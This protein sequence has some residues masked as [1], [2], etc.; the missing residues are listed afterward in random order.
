MEYGPFSFFSPPQ[1][2][3]GN[4]ESKQVGI[5]A[6]ELGAKAVLIVTD[7]GII[8]AGLA[9][10]IK[11]VL[12]RSDIDVTI[13]D[14]VD[15]NPSDKT[16]EKGERIFR[17]GKF[18][19]IIGLGGGSSMDTA[20]AIKAMAMTG[21]PLLG[22]ENKWLDE[23]H[24]KKKVSLF[25]IPTTAGTGSEV[26]EVAVIKD[27]KRNKKLMI[28][29]YVIRPEMAFC[30]PL[31]T[32]SLPP[33][34]TAATGIDAL[35][36]AIGSFTN[37]VYHPFAEIFDIKAIELIYENLPMVMANPQD[38]ESRYKMMLGALFAG[39]GISQTGIDLTHAISSQ[40]EA[41][42][43]CTHGEVLGVLIPHCMD[44]NLTANLEKFPLIGQAMGIELKTLSQEEAGKKTVA[45][46]KSFISDLGMY[47]RL[48]SLGISGEKIPQM[49][50]AAVG[51]K[52][53][54]LNSRD[55]K[56]EDIDKVFHAAY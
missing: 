43:D 14:E 44:F 23:N 38:V 26:T 52:S 15:P 30:D 3:F 55:V 28:L 22:I 8:K 42:F 5:K 56:A 40:V 34:M 33:K 36:H 16:V 31:L 11:K 6:K 53:A 54:A 2:V 1:I 29:G 27:K 49:V 13:F 24:I 35:S 32:V 47:D 37:K 25:V 19:L 39:F 48:S 50:Q 45:V 51:T 4:G 21:E 9:D 20:K 46:L 17:E 10:D 7:K 41:H 12:M 18:D